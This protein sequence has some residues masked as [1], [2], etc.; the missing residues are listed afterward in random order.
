VVKSELNNSV[1]NI[2]CGMPSYSYNGPVATREFIIGFCGKWYPVIELQSENKSNNIIKLCYHGKDIEDFESKAIKP[3]KSQ[4]HKLYN[5]KKMDN[6]YSAYH[7]FESKEV[8]QSFF[9]LESPLYVIKSTLREYG[10]WHLP[11]YEIVINSTLKSY[12]FAKIYDPYSAC[13]EIE[14]FLGGVL[15]NKE[16]DQVGI[17]DKYLKMQKGFDKWSF[18]KMPTKNKHKNK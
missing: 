1:S 15:G 18:K 4:K 9:D 16:I 6:V 10:Q 13:Q 17:E 14:M 12:D 5:I 11:A 3:T 2:F 7:G 8:L